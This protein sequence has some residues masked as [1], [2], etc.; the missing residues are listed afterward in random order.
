MLSEQ[1]IKTKHKVGGNYAHYTLGV[2][3]IVYMFE[4]MDKSLISIL[5]EDIKADLGTTDAQMG[6]FGRYGVWPLLRAVRHSVR[7]LSRRLDTSKRTRY[8]AFVLEPG[9]GTHWPCAVILRTHS[10]SIRDG[11]W[12]VS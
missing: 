6:F 5:A 2:L 3:W 8:R 9:N 12:Y 10:I 1:P 11:Y 7:A 4:V